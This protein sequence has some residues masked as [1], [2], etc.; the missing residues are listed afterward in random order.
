MK[1]SEYIAK[2]EEIKTHHG[3]LEVQTMFGDCRREEAPTPVLDFVA[4]LKGRESTPRFA[5]YYKWEADFDNRKGAKVCR[6]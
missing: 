4:N 5:S 3:D 6:I 1:I 2:L